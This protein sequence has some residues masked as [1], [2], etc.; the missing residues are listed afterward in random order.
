MTTRTVALDNVTPAGERAVLQYNA[1]ED[2][3]KLVSF[4]DIF[5]K[6]SKSK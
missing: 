2:K 4:D 3:F 5:S 1:A 6:L